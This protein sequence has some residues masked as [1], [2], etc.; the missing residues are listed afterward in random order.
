MRF[1]TCHRLAL[2]SPLRSIVVASLTVLIVGVVH[3]QDRVTI[4]PGEKLPKAVTAGDPNVSTDELELLVKPMTVTEL[5]SEK[6]AWMELVKAK[7]REISQ[8][9][10]AVK[11]QN[12]Q[13][14]VK[15][16]VVD[17]V[18]DAQKAIE[19]AGNADDETKETAAE[20]AEAAV[21]T[22][23]AAVQ[24]A[25]A[26]PGA[27][28]AAVDV[29]KA[30][31]QGGEGL[32]KASEG[33]QQQIARD[34]EVKGATLDELTELRT[35][36]AALIDRLRIVLD[37]LEK[38]GGA[39]EEERYYIAAVSGITVDVSDQEAAR[40]AIAGWLTSEEGGRRIGGNLLKFVL[41]LIAAWIV[42]RIVG[43]IL[44]RALRVN[45]KLSK[46][47]RD[48][49]SKTVRKIVLGVGLVLALSA[50]EVDIAPVLALIGAAGFVVAFALQGTLSNFASGI[51]ILYY[52]PFDVGDWVDVAGISGS[53]ASLNLVSTTIC[54]GDNKKVIVPNNSIWGDVITNATGTAQRRV[55]MVF[56]I[57]YGDD[58]AQAQAIL[59]KVVS[60]HPAVLLEPETV[61]RV[62][63]LADS[64]VNFIVRPWVKTED[65]WPT[66]W[67]LT[68]TV[69]EAFD[70]A[71]VSIPFPQRDVHVFHEA[72]PANGE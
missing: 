25:V 49:L 23:D 57:G 47:M 22:A 1:I 71:G 35:G 46:L 55:D 63:E 38:K 18:T 54:T 39:A 5:T 44:D 56:G 48:F 69:K 19:K 50:L 43:S 14:A 24:E 67:D 60:E 52:K 42:S 64:S 61:I 59:E 16:E 20:A 9:E 62:N 41:I 28:D 70:A 72:A 2:P 13:I 68:R 37:E 6:N 15:K 45:R 12:A 7:V 27:G 40:A 53:V 31:A 36:R 66:Y 58:M 3:A 11:K 30:A 32:A 51:M 21:D 34:Q 29:K 65:Y 26:A 33:V 8:R 10:I 4:E 17:A